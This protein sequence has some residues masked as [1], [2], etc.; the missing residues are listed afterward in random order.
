MK[1]RVLVIIVTY[2]A[3]QWIDRCMGSLR[4][5]SQ[6]VDVFVVDNGSS[7]G[8]PE[9]VREIGRGWFAETAFD[10]SGWWL[11]QLVENSENLGFG[12]ANNLGLKFALE[13]GYKYIYLL[14]Q[15]AWVEPDTI[16]GLITA[17]EKN[18]TFGVVSP[19]QKS[20]SGELDARFESKCGR[21]LPDLKSGLKPSAELY[22]VPFVMAAH[23]L[24][25]RECLEK[26]GGFSPAFPH[27]GED[28]NFLHRCTL[29]GFRC[30][31][32]ILYSATHDREN[33]Q[34]SKP[35]RMHLKYVGAI[36]AL[37]NPCSPLLWNLLWQPL[38][39]LGIALINA[40]PASA[41]DAFRLIGHYPK[42]VRLRSASKKDLPFL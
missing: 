32:D 29:K 25:S 27:Y 40:Y 20:A 4:E 5:S 11:A 24:I 35:Q 23:W 13:N 37:S 38:K 3:M 19:L 9:R 26:V 33:R 41:L 39:L 30:G 31:V 1:N 18:P 8:T 22:E 21:Y 17:I 10:S 6:S 16:T 42:F 2:N 28:D 14:N 7:D 34:Q 36:V 15:D 12:A